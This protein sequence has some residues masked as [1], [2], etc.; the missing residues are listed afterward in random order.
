[1][2][3]AAGVANLFVGKAWLCFVIFHYF[4]GD[5]SGVWW[6]SMLGASVAA[7]AGARGERGSEVIRGHGRSGVEVSDTELLQL[8]LKG[9]LLTAF[10]GDFLARE[11]RLRAFLSQTQQSA[12]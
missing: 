4:V 11:D 9:P 12:M 5:S 2:V 10:Q 7:G 6:E 3:G 1:M 8:Q